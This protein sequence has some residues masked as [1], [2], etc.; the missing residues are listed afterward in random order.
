MSAVTPFTAEQLVAIE[1]RRGPFALAANAGSGKTSVLVERYV[2][3]VIEDGIAPAR[4]LA[5]TFTDRAAGELRER[6]RARLVAEGRRAAARESAA[7][8]VSTFHGF[9]ARVLRSHAVLAGLPAD[10]GVLGDAQAATLRERAFDEA[11]AGWLDGDGG[12]ELAASFGVEELRAALSSTYDEVRSRGERA[13]ALPAPRAAPRR[14]DLAR[15]ARWRPRR[16]SSA[17]SSRGAAPAVLGALVA[18][19]CG[20]PRAVPPRRRGSATSRCRG[21]ATARA[22]PPSH[23]SRP[24]RA[25][26]R[27][28]P[29]GSAWRRWR[30]SDELLC[31]RSASATRR[32]SGSAGCSTSTTSS[33]RRGRC[34]RRTRRSARCGRSGSSS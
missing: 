33:S 15:G 11:L 21:A 22:Q 12:L 1:R 16:P 3:A 30:C 32:A 26:R 25:S 13:P 34:S 20:A 24:G 14:G 8:H 27:P 29:T 6:M 2:R 31:A 18:S 17:A 7:A 23:T 9:C 5:I 10:F 28:A 19:S 4:I